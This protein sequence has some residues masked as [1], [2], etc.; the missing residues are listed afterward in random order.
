MPQLPKN[1]REEVRALVRD[2]GKLLYSY[3]PGNQ[4]AQSITVSQKSDGTSVTNADIAAHESIVAGLQ[5]ITPDIA[6]LSEEDESNTEEWL[7]ADTFWITD[8]L[9]GTTS[10]S[11]GLED[12]SVL[13]ALCVDHRVVLSFMYFPASELFIEAAF[14]EGATVNDEILRVSSSLTPQSERVYFRNVEDPPR[15]WDYG[16]RLD[17][18]RAFYKLVEGSFDGVVIQMTRHNDWDIAAPSLIVEEAGGHVTDASGAALEFGR[19]RRSCDCV[20]ATNGLTH[21]AILSV[22]QRK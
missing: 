22:L 9:D 14:G 7:G 10:F 15:E 16:K 11:K 12:F 19:S 18:G 4:D 13:L 2:V 20:V 17:S 6:I 5:E 21:E 1:H 8:P 3:W